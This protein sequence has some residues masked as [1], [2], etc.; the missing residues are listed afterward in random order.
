MKT[1]MSLTPRLLRAILTVTIALIVVAGAAG[2]WFAHSQLAAYATVVNNDSITAASGEQNVTKL[3]QLKSRMDA[4]P[5]AISRAANIVA[6]S[7]YY[8]YQDQIISDLTSYANSAGFQ[9]TGFSFTP[10]AT[11]T[12]TTGSSSPAPAASSSMPTTPL[13]PTPAGLKIEYA[14]VT[15]PKDVAYTA[16]V[17]F[18]KSIEENLTKMEVM[19]VSMQLDPDNGLLSPS[20]LTIGVYT[21]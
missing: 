20:P 1:S 4:D 21:R 19:G 6:D 9:I 11:S 12:P 10:S 8:Q 3:E 2:L 7:K 13:A 15:F 17:K 14:T 16:Y 18:L 5:V